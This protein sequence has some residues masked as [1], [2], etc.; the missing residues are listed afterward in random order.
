M[1]VEGD[2]SKVTQDAHYN[3][4]AVFCGELKGSLWEKRKEPSWSVELL[5]A[6][7]E[8]ADANLDPSLQSPQ[9]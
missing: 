6:L 7:G 2:F 5:K 1:C 8:N 3:V 4:T 9:L